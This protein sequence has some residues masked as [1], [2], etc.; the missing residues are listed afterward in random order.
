MTR[1]FISFFLLAVFFSAAPASKEAPP[2]TPQASSTAF[3]LQTLMPASTQEKT[4]ID[5]LSKDQLGALN[6]WF[7]NYLETQK[8][9][10]DQVAKNA[11]SVVLSE[12]HYVK[13]GSG[14]I[15][16]ISPNAWI[17]TFYWQKGDPI[18]VGTSQDVLFPVQLTNKNFNQSVNAKKS[19]N[20][21]TQSFSQSYPISK[22]SE[23]GQFITLSNGSS[24]QVEPSAR[25]LSQGWSTGDP[26]FVVKV[27]NA[28]GS[29]YELYNG[30]TARS[31]FVSQVKAPP[32]AN[33]KS[34][35]KK[36]PQKTNA[37]QRAANPTNSSARS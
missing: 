36:Q 17:Y 37:P 22:I 10:A 32:T 20:D 19:S 26:I 34:R 4:G 7:S 6:S 11:V 33:S 35:S 12:G 14:Q 29:P 2:T 3:N 21:V 27:K 23:G 9:S 15:W 30:T 1:Y 16:T 13:L 24:W 5:Q 18:E 8:N 25:Y 31:V 28:M